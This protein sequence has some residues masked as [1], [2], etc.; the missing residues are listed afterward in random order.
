MNVEALRAFL[1]DQD[2]V[3]VGGGH[4]VNLPAVWQ[5]D[6]THGVIEKALPCRL[7]DGATCH[8]C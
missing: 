6:D 4:T 8:G 7:P 1:L 3:Y 5:A 2:V